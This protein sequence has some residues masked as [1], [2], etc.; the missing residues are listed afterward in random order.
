[1]SSGGSPFDCGEALVRQRG[2]CDGC[3]ASAAGSLAL[4]RKVAS[5][6]GGPRSKAG[7]ALAGVSTAGGWLL[8]WSSRRSRRGRGVAGAASLAAAA[9]PAA[10]G[11]GGCSCGCRRGVPS[12]EAD[13]SASP[14]LRSQATGGTGMPVPFAAMPLA[15][16]GANGG[17]RRA[18][19]AG[20]GSTLGTRRAEADWLWCS[21]CNRLVRSRGG[22][23][24]EPPSSAAAD[25]HRD[26]SAAASRKASLACSLVP[27]LQLMTLSA[28][29]A[30]GTAALPP[31]TAAAGASPS[32]AL[33]CPAAAVAPADFDRGM[34]AFCREDDVPCDGAAAP[35][36]RPS[37]ARPRSPRRAERAVS[38]GDLAESSRS[39][40]ACDAASA[41]AGSDEFTGTM[42]RSGPPRAASCEAAPP[43]P[44]SLS[45]W[46]GPSSRSSSSTERR[47]GGPAA[48]L[49][50][51]ASATLRST[52]PSASRKPHGGKHRAARGAEAVASSVPPCV[53]ARC[54]AGCEGP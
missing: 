33:R 29:V 37:L 51:L 49:N 48:A 18:R 23:M 39:S 53:I 31:C 5:L 52:W 46:P 4:G 24:P 7:V 45:R 27:L 54:A 2:S 17:V 26:A 35:E 14:C 13:A 44:S 50:L 9:S 25:G 11:G 10:R 47:C 28:A 20:A 21:A 41:S 22:A 40:A 43:P 38:K 8:L 36:R 6:E 34:S 3:G 42:G 30:Q 15:P 16:R 12:S 19:C 32:P 1:M